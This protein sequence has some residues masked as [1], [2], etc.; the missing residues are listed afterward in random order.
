MK[1]TLS[2]LLV[3]M[4]VSGLTMAQ[5]S[6]AGYVNPFIGTGGHGHTYPGATMPFGMVQL[7]PD[8]RLEGWD[9]CGGYH[10]D[11]TYIYG[12]T[13]THLNG[14]G[15]PDLCDILFMPT[16]G[17]TRWNN[18]SDGKP[19][20]GS[21][22]KHSSESAEPGYYKVALD[23]Y[24]IITELSAT[25]RAGMHCYTFPAGTA[26][27]ILVDLF[28]RDEVLESSLKVISDTQIEGLRRS[29][30]WANN[31]Y[32]Y[33]VAEF[34]KPFT[35][36]EIAVD[37]QTQAGLKSAV[38]N[39]KNIKAI[40]HFSTTAGE[41]I[42]VKVGISAVNIDGARL[43]LKAEIPGWDFDLVRKSATA[44]WE[45]ELSKIEIEG[46]TDLQKTV[47]YT[48]LYHTMVN[49]NTYMDVDGS[50][51]GR[52]LKVHKD[53]GF[54]NY[55]VFSLWD[56]YRAYN[57]LMTI[58]D[59]KRTL[60]Y[61][62]TFLV[63]Y[64]Q[65]GLLPVWELAGN[66]TNCMIGY[67]AVPVIVDAYLKGIRGFDTGKALEAMRKSAVRTDNA[68]LKALDQYGFISTED[69][70][71]SV[72]KTLEYAYD[73]WCIAQ[74]A[75]SIGKNDDY[76]Y[77]IKRG[78]NFKN[79]YDAST[80]FMRAR[81]NGG[82]FSPFDPFEVNFNYTEAN[83]W[84]YSFSAVQ[85]MDGLIRLHGGQ[86]NLAKKLDEL[87]SASPKTSGRDQSDITGLIGQYAHGNEP[88]HHIAYL[89][90]FVGQ[91]W[92][93]Q[94]LVHRI[95][96]TLYHNDPDGLTGNEDCG[97]MSAWAVMSAM[98]FYPVTPGADFYVIG[99]PW[100]SKVT[101]N[102]E[103][104]KKFVISAGNISDN[105]FYIQS[106]TL[107]GKKYAASYLKHTDIMNGGE[108]TF[109]MGDKPD[110]KWGSGK[111]NQPVTAITDNLIV[112]SPTISDASKSFI[113]KKEI[114]IT[115]LEGASISFIAAGADGKSSVQPY[116]G[117]FSI[118]ETSKIRFNAQKKGV[119]SPWIYAKFTR[120]ADDKDIKLTY[121]PAN[122][123]SS[124]GANNLIDGIRCSPDFRVGGWL[125]F[126]KVNLEAVIDLRK[127]KA[128]STFGAGFLQ[129]INAWI[130][131]PSQLEFFVSDNGTDYR[132][133]VVVKNDVPKEKEGTILKTFEI[134]VDPVNARYVKVIA[135][136]IGN[137]PPGH[138]GQGGPAW[139][140]ADEVI[141]K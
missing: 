31:Q 19:G 118:T 8:T 65:G 115:G 104:G 45:K 140:F 72:S 27:N 116:K 56:T 132:S 75:K 70:S 73:D 62:K 119:S 76:K 33:F 39:K 5:K 64:D 2:L 50:Y 129:D 4:L 87:F 54:T 137:C 138:K 136:N 134:Q 28:H 107:N 49:P 51:R 24:N 41:K 57:P 68:G 7:S 78:Q 67:H 59:Q 21:H 114:S 103:N 71:E 14:T 86:E 6:P 30:S 105:N 117:P 79:V 110:K 120:M 92:K 23:D 108:L 74:F 141:I 109:S 26:S 29:R 13:H 99:T 80:G 101:I 10:Y 25:M 127:V 128:V 53:A 135:S 97:Q 1:T 18:G 46:G 84:Q 34:S 82:W 44:A 121:P 88:S 66:E 90:P 95:L 122:Q 20:Y 94:E 89:Y 77:F 91:P 111:K 124:G 85:D 9:G 47:F 52:D 83:S 61:I 102:L 130:F 48:A 43:N 98:G 125:G 35:S 16:T 22:F 42:L 32:V 100:F 38:N 81:S 139:M 37:N 123:Y 63:Q 133:I 55:S 17:E 36:Y 12:F 106:A 60:D 69:E 3:L 58:I 93:T 11:D 126:E 131:M 113:D 96:N 15:V 40:F 112:A